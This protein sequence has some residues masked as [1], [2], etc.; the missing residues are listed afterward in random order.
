MPYG[1]RMTKIARS[2]WVITGAAGNIGSALRAALLE[3]GVDLVSTDILSTA[4]VGPRDSFVQAALGDLES[5]VELFVGVDGVI[6]LGGIADEADFHDLADANI[7]GTY[8][9]L[10]AARRSGVPRVV[11]A[12]SNRLTGMYPSSEHVS[13]D[14]PPRP[15]GFYGVSKVAGEALCRLYADKFGLSTIS[16]RIGSYENRPSSARENVCSSGSA[17]VVAG[18]KGTSRSYTIRETTAVEC[19]LK[20]PAGSL[21]NLAST[22]YC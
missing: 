9:V 6:H 19:G 5:L 10:E 14:M 22:R 17:G 7:I 16:V 2:R 13:P 1:L 3:L 18:A 20:T 11:F 12:S 15:D 21:A 8:H 4:P